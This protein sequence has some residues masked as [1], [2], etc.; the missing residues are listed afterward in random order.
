[1]EN[2]VPKEASVGDAVSQPEKKRF[3][4]RKWHVLSIVL[5][6]IIV[7]QAFLYFSLTERYR[8]LDSQHQSLLSEYAK[9]ESDYSA[10]RSDY[11]SL[12]SSYS[13]LLASYSSLQAS[14]GTL[15]ASHSSLESSYSSLQASH[16]SL[17]SSYS[18]LQSS[19]SALQSSYDSLLADYENLQSSFDSAYSDYANLRDQINQ[20]ILHLDVGDF[21]TPND[22]SVESVV[23][24]ITGGWSD[25]SDWDEYWSD[26]EAMY[27]W[28]VS[29]I[30]YRSDGLFPILPSVPSGSVQ[31]DPEMWQFPNETLGLMEGDCEDMA[32]LLTS[33][34]R[35]YNDEQYAV[36]CIWIEGSLG[37]HVAVQFPVE[38][39]E[40]TILDPAGQY[41]TKDLYGDLTSEEIS[42]EINNWLDRWKPLMGSDV[43]V[44]RVFSSYVDQ[45]FSSTSEYVAWMYN[46]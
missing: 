12:Q 36:E 6:V 42:T 34:M 1:M 13:S 29:N 38:D 43:R 7:A 23:F 8:V 5:V 2:E 33:M 25:P 18:S 28:V 31:Y 22:T 27:Q 37:A 16:S 30:A 21:I 15:Q 45:S 11:D 10:L 32:I 44:D 14:Y 17:Q 26:V 3:R 39:D 9:L 19:Y 40:L 4:L 46:R 24:S 20:R 41:F 35:S